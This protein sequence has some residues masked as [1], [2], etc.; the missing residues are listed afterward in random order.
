MEY[1]AGDDAIF[2]HQYSQAWFDFRNKRDAYADYFENSVKAT[3]A[4]KLFC[5]SLHERFPDYDENLWGIS[6]SDY[7]KGY[8]A[9]GGPSVQGGPLWPV[10]GGV[11]PGAT[12]GFL[13]CFFWDC[14]CLC[15]N[16]HCAPPDH[17]WC[18]Y[19]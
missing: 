15:R 9:W 7:V 11:V 17:M 13:P 10:D 5:L 4:H 1:I 18:S 16:L 19:N 2:T 8:T 14:I 6:A 12:G 3:K